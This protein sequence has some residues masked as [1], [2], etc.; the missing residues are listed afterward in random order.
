M[1]L[2]KHLLHKKL[3]YSHISLQ[4]LKSH[5][6]EIDESKITIDKKLDEFHILA[7]GYLY[8]KKNVDYI[9]SVIT[10]EN[11][12]YLKYVKLYQPIDPNLPTIYSIQKI[13]DSPT[14]SY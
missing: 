2:P 12:P 3:K 1:I 5:C 7:Y 11:T 13:Q 10:L 9:L 6:E 4:E 8:N 14:K